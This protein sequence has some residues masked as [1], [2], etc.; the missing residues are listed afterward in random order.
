MDVT[1][2]R[3]V[4]VRGIDQQ[5]S[6]DECIAR[7]VAQEKLDAAAGLVSLR[8]VKC[9]ARKP[10]GEE[11]QQAV[12]LDDPSL[13]LEEAGIMSTAWLI[14]CVAGVATLPAIEDAAERAVEKN[15]ALLLKAAGQRVFFSS[16]TVAG[17]YRALVKQGVIQSVDQPSWFAAA[18][19][20]VADF[21][22][23]STLEP[24][25]AEMAVQVE[26]EERVRGLAR[27]ADHPTMV[28][29]GRS[30]VRSFGTRKPDIAAFAVA[31]VTGVPPTAQLVTPLSRD[32]MHICSLGDLK[33]R[34]SVGKE[35]QFT[36][37]EKGSLLNFAQEL[38]TSQT[39]RAHSG[40]F[41]R[42]PIFLSDGAHI[43]FFECTY[44][45]DIGRR[46]VDVRLHGVRESAPMPLAGP[47]G[48]LLAGLTR[49]PLD[50]L[51]YTLPRVTAPGVQVALQ[52]FL[53]LGATA[54]G[55]LGDWNGAPVLY[56][57]YHATTERLVRDMELLALE[58]TNGCPGICRLVSAT[59]EGLLLAPLG[60]QAYSLAAASHGA[61]VR[62]RSRSAGLWRE[63]VPPD[64]ML[65]TSPEVR[66][67]ALEFCDLV[68]ALAEMHSRGWVHRDARPTNWFRTGRGYFF[69]ADL[70]SASPMG[71]PLTADP[72][73]W[74][75]QY[76]PLASLRAL[77]L[78][79]DEVPE[80]AHDFEQVARLVYCTITS[81][82]ERNS[83]P[84]A[85]SLL[86]L[87]AWWE[88]RDKLPLLRSLLDAAADA[89]TDQLARDA[90]KACIR[91]HFPE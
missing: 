7:W 46:Q 13:S 36:D 12:E 25:A 19:S 11:E 42:L 66:P 59:P 9:G 40:A 77:A 28:L 89:A 43:V 68:D 5:V 2:A 41:A 38:M 26:F 45:V 79:L 30:T 75:P 78:G 16:Q 62:E 1:G 27:A 22:A 44:R 65:S 85:S 51:G 37:A 56:K 20:L 87:C 6:V 82:A 54:A 29:E 4:A 47:G 76:G 90:L 86:E 63:G 83:L 52:S 60:A 34:R 73:P 67:T 32:A 84:S 72:R 55:F 81:D 35:G 24:G 17:D 57:R 15:T 58:G 39:W 33:A 91:S 61:P 8:L 10:S 64:L 74:A 71:R 80:P 50:A 21:A 31:Q 23:A 18:P 14:A 49:A 3:Y 70:G 88:K 53:G 69:L 48:M